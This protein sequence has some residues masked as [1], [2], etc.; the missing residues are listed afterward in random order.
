MW[1]E[2]I[3]DNERNRV[4]TG[5]AVRCAPVWRVPCEVDAKAAAPNG[6]VG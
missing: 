4:G 6:G 1:A 5:A 2:I 3:V